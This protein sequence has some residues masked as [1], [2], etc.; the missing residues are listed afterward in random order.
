MSID[1]VV[2]SLLGTSTP[3]HCKGENWFL[4]PGGIQY[5]KPCRRTPSVHIAGEHYCTDHAPRV[6]EA[7]AA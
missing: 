4:G 2:T 6:R 3:E 5:W 1:R 7:G